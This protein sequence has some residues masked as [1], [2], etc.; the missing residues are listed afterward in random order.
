M[1]IAEKWKI[2]FIVS[3]I[4]MALGLISLLIP[5]RGMNLGI[6]FTGGNL[7]TLR[8][9]GAVTEMAIREV[10]S[11]HDLGGSAIQMAQARGGNLSA[12]QEVI[13]QTPPVTAERKAQVLAALEAKIGSFEKLGDEAVDAAFSRELRT[14]AFLAL[15]FACLG[16]IA[17]ITFRFEFKFAI[18]AILAL[19]HDAFIV[20][21]VFSLLRIPISATFVAAILTIV[22]YS[23]NDTI[24]IFDRLRENLKLRRGVS[25]RE[26]V[27]TSINE[28][29]TRS[30]NTSLTTLSTVAAVL[31]LGGSTLRDFS[32][33][34]VLGII[35]GTYSSIFIASPVW[36]L[37][38]ESEQRKLQTAGKRA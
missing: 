29:L 17:Y 35:V 12:A 23:I 6:D 31:L 34:L 18:A 14:K 3:G 15:L 37:W 22:G 33:A 10:L 21:G 24:V 27:D 7:L 32:L 25:L 30:I 5:G 13:I 8:F 26:L 4:I 19:M 28:S 20:I 9:P 38:K 36:M 2:W 11:Q 1:K 16:M